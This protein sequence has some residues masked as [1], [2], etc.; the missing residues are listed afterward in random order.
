[1]TVQAT[2]YR[3][4]VAEAGA[5]SQGKPFGIC[6]GHSG[7][8]TGFSLTI[9]CLLSNIIPPTLHIRLSIIRLWVMSP[10]VV[11]VLRDVLTLHPVI[12]FN[13]LLLINVLAQQP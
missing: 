1:M 5:R 6:G 3:L 9:F 12:Q 4:L 11:A 8:G 10:A 13:S 7:R 2:R